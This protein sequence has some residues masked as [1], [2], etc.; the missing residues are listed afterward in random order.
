MA[1]FSRIFAALIA[2]LMLGVSAAIAQSLTPSG[3]PLPG[4]A[5]GSLAWGDYNADGRPDLLVTGLTGP[6]EGCGPVSRV[7]R[8]D[9]TRF[10]DAGV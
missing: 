1:G 10:S 2:F 8:N 7:Y 3:T 6:A 9:I 4:T 5:L